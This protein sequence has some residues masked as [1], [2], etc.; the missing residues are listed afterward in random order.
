MQFYVFESV[1]NYGMTLTLFRYRYPL[2]SSVHLVFRRR[3]YFVVIIL[4]SCYG[5]RSLNIRLYDIYN[6]PKINYASIIWSRGTITQINALNEGHKRATRC[7]L[8]TPPRP[9]LDGYLTYEERCNRLK[10]RTLKK[11]R[12]LSTA[13][14]CAKILKNEVKTTLG[15]EMRRAQMTNHTN[16]RRTPNIFNAATR[17]KSG[18]PL[19][20]ITSALQRL[21][22]GINIEAD[23]IITIKRKLISNLSRIR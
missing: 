12:D 8:A 3:T 15:E 1:F 23:S 6:A 9:H 2:I 14:M 13:L 10:T 17:F 4:L 7:A 16:T 18:S 19:Q 20:R 21:G 11:Q 5:N 22:N